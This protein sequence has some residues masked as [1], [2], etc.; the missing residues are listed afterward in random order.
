[1]HVARRDSDVKLFDA[2]VRTATEHSDS[3]LGAVDETNSA[4]RRDG[5]AEAEGSGKREPWHKE[6][7][8]PL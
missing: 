5:G 8:D 2:F 1:M 7:E 6:K 3:A 4:T